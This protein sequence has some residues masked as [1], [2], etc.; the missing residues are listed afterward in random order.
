[1]AENGRIKKIFPLDF[2]TGVSRRSKKA[3]RGKEDQRRRGYDGSEIEGYRRLIR[4][5][6]VLD[7]GEAMKKRGSRYRDGSLYVTNSLTHSILLAIKYFHVG[8]DGFSVPLSAPQR[9]SYHP[10]KATQG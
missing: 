5:A 7:P 3:G 6:L 2:G 4:V 10:E 1:M 9:R 8:T